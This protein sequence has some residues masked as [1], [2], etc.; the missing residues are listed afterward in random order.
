MYV[1]YTQQKITV[2]FC[3]YI[4]IKF[5]YL[6]TLLELRGNILVWILDFKTDVNDLYN[7]LWKGK[8]N[9]YRVSLVIY[10]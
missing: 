5:E 4:S 9:R 6:K 7:L 3:M 2:K 10:N 1:I 8:K